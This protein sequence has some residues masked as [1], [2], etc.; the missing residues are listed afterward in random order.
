MY[1]RRKAKADILT[2]HINRANTNR[3]V[4]SDAA[5]RSLSSSSFGNS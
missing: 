2:V 3:Q 5:V 1:A 4:K